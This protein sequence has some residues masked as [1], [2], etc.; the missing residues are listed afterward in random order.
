MG[1]ILCSRSCPGWLRSTALVLSFRWKHRSRD[2][3]RSIGIP[4]EMPDWNSQQRIWRPVVSEKRQ[5]VDTHGNYDAKEQIHFRHGCVIP[6]VPSTW[7]ILLSIHIC[8]FDHHFHDVIAKCN[9]AG[10]TG[11]LKGVAESV[12]EWCI[13]KAR[14]TEFNALF[15]S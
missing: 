9:M 1:L 6:F 8:L 15:V 14:T 5:H 10:P 12:E 7:W 4:A 2:L 11:S 13:L 3:N